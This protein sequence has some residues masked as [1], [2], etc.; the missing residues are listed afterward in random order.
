MRRPAAVLVGTFVA[1]LTFAGCTLTS[2]GDLATPRP[3]GDATLP[4]V[5][6]APGT[7]PT[8]RFP[9][10]PPPSSLA[11]EVLVE[12]DGPTVQA[13]DLIVA[14]YLGQVWDGPVFDSSYARGQV[15]VERLRSLVPGWADGLTGRTVGSRVLL[16]VPP[17]EGYGTVGKPGT[18]IG[19]GDTIV[20]VVDLIGSF[21]TTACG[22]PHATAAG[23]P[24]DGVVVSG[25]PGAP[26]SIRVVA[27][28][29]APT[30][31]SATVLA[32][33][34]GERLVA[35]TALVQI[36]ATDWAGK[37][38]G[39]TWD[40]SGPIQVSTRDGAPYAGLAAVPVGSRVLVILPSSGDVPAVASVV[41][42]LAQ[43]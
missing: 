43:T 33:G 16:S 9:S 39:S 12:G 34:T 37:D 17:S 28:T 1:V 13:N 4:E 40:D 32:R 27:G 31:A 6:G 22:D 23:S 26:P 7:A 35:G 36:A 42:V 38:P 29:P 14:D 21:G 20:F 18:A 10:T 30:A 11:S 5:I 41:D 25:L 24:P 2:T 3:S 19:G 8:L 15:L